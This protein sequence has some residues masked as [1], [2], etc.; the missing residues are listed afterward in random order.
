MKRASR[1]PLLTGNELGI[2]NDHS[3]CGTNA[4]VLAGRQSAGVRVEAPCS[5]RTRRI[6]WWTMAAPSRPVLARRSRRLL[7]E[8]L[9]SFARNLIGQHR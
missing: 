7:A 3:E 9:L 5:M 6:T 8:F 1:E 4:P 2:A